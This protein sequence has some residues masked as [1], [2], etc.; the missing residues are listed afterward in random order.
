MTKEKVLQKE[1]VILEGEFQSRQAALDAQKAIVEYNSANGGVRQYREQVELSKQI[2][3][4]KDEAV[5][6]GNSEFF[7]LISEMNTLTERK[8]KLSEANVRALKAYIELKK[9]VG[10]LNVEDLAVVSKSLSTR[11]KN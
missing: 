1:S 10:T 9:A 8:N 6:A 2:V 5:K 7:Q 3:K 4:S 11:N